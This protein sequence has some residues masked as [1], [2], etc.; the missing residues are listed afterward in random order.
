MVYDCDTKLMGLSPTAG[1][2]RRKEMG[3]IMQWEAS[4]V[5]PA[6]WAPG[7]TKT[8]M[9]R[10]EVIL[11]FPTTIF[12]GLAPPLPPRVAPELVF[13]VPPSYLRTLPISHLANCGLRTDQS[14]MKTQ[15][16]EG[17]GG[18]RLKK[19]WS[20]LYPISPHLSSPLWSLPSDNR[21]IR[22]SQGSGHCPFCCPL[23]SGQQRVSVE[24]TSPW[25]PMELPGA[26]AA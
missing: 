8:E 19:W 5:T 15:P 11:F 26:S 1:P 17:A 18:E 14:P 6:G 10:V 21:R 23:W 3:I 2:Q 22:Y 4:T 13:T 20:S 12:F 25:G 16:V 7:R 24:P 9:N